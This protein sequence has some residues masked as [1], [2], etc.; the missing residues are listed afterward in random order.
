M[1]NIDG[2][3]CAILLKHINLV[4]TTIFNIKEHKKTPKKSKKTQNVDSKSALKCVKQIK[5]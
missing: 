2:L 1:I 5:D 3:V 4:F